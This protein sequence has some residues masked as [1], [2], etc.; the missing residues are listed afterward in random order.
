MI[1]I[2]FCPNEGGGGG[3][4]R[5]FILFFFPCSTDH[6]RDWPPCEVVF[7]GLAVNTLNVR[8]NNNNNFIIAYYFVRGDDANDVKYKS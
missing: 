6:E 5:L 1:F 2:L 4:A 8:N 3:A 7:F